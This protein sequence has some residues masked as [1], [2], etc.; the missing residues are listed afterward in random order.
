MG[1]KEMTEYKDP[2]Q[3]AVVTVERAGFDSEET[4]REAIRL[5]NSELD[6][7]DFYE[8]HYEGVRNLWATEKLHIVVKGLSGGQ[9]G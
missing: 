4:F 8:A 1:Y 9:Q 3:G 5:V 7:V 6:K 2:K